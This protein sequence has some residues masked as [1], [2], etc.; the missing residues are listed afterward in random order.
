[1]SLLPYPDRVRRARRSLDRAQIVQAALDLLDEIGLDG[2]TMRNVAERLGVRATALYRHVR[3]KDELLVL[4]AD[5]ISGE[6]EP[7]GQEPPWQERLTEFAWRVRRG[8]LVHRDAARLLAAVAP[9]GLRRMDHIEAMLR[10]LIAAGFSP[11]VAV[12]AAYHFN[13]LVTEFAADEARL[14]SSA[15]AAGASPADLLAEGRRQLRALPADRYP[16]L[17]EH[18]DLLAEDDVD[19]RFR[20]GVELLVRGLELIRPG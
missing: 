16:T 17:V 10:L 7:I 8:L 14:A 1:M 4:L 13:N 12:R 18:A 9:A 11:L 5:Q 20:L 3:D 19:G 6:V 2:L 15:A